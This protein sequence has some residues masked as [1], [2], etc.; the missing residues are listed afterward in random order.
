MIDKLRISVWLGIFC[1]IP[2]IS[3][4]QNLDSKAVSFPWRIV[5]ISDLDGSSLLTVN[6][7]DQLV[8][9]TDTAKKI[10]SFSFTTH[11]DSTSFNGTWQLES[12]S[13]VLT[14]G[15]IPIKSDIDS[16]SYLTENDQA[17][18][19][20]FKGEEEIARQ[21]ENGIFSEARR[22]SFQVAVDERGNLTLKGAKRIIQ[23][24][25]RNELLQ[26]PF[27][28]MD[29][30]R[31]MIGIVF[32][33]GLAWLFSTNRKAIDW[34]LVGSGL[35][36]QLVFAL[37]VLKV[38]WINQGFSAI[39]E[40]FVTVLDFTLAGSSF[41]FDWLVD[42]EKSG[43]IFALQVV[44]IIIFFSALTSLLYYLG[45]LQKIVYGF[46]WVMSKTMRLSGA[47]SLAAAGNIFLGQTESPLLIKPYLS[48]MTRSE[49]MA[50]MTGGMATIAGSV[51]GAYIGYLG[52]ADPAQ[53]TLF[54]THLLTASIMSA[55]AALVLA[56]MLVPETGEVIQD[57]SVPKEKLGSNLLD[58][59]ANGTT[60]G[61]KLGVNVVIML[62]VFLAMIKAANFVLGDLFGYY[63]GL[64][65]WVA[66]STNGKFSAFGLEYLFGLVL[67]P[68]AW[69][70]G[71]PSDDIMI[72]GQLLGEK[73]VA[74]EFVAYA[75]LGSMTASGT[76]V[77]YKSLIIATYALC[78]FA[79]FSSIGI[80][81]GGIG[82]LAPS[83]R[84]TLSE[85]GIRAMIG[86]TLAAF[87]T[88][89]LAGMLFN[90]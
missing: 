88:A 24:G 75:S 21:T 11:A 10:N 14:Y 25:G 48:K 16:I 86:G 56:K 59:I 15:L 67:S 84:K 32:L 18:I 39:S 64:N 49:I 35:L 27:S 20:Y 79:N 77:H 57:L 19:I 9:S 81:I 30:V 70:M 37:L 87:M 42:V 89:I 47:E 51:F 46:A 83:Q 7:A 78:G 44:P 6:P 90:I 54:A 68:V 66:E 2:F 4:S 41:L 36:L 1:L 43:Y 58:A 29:V 3:I 50:L 40:G 34:R 76:I 22:E 62:L 85:L 52:G 63:T 8:I 80:Q 53:K 38:G 65:E 31:A 74:N 12:D 33:L 73:T 13:I 60:E 26:S 17:T 61:L 28:F 23:L 72:I 5:A 55:P 45:I 82:A 69:L 71:V